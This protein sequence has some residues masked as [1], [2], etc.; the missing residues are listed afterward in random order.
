MFPLGTGTNASRGQRVVEPSYSLPSSSHGQ[1]H[2]SDDVRRQG[3]MLVYEGAHAHSAAW[4]PESPH[5]GHQQQFTGMQDGYFHQHH[6]AHY[7]S[8]ALPL[9]PDAYLTSQ[10]PFPAPAYNITSTMP[11][12]TSEAPG[13]VHSAPPTWPTFSP[14]AG[15]PAHMS[16]PSTTTAASPLGF[17]PWDAFNFSHV[18]HPHTSDYSTLEGAVLAPTVPRTAAPTSGASDPV[19][20]NMD[21]TPPNPSSLWPN[22][23]HGLSPRISQQLSDERSQSES[24]LPRTHHTARIPPESSGRSS[25]I[26]GQPPSSLDVGHSAR[27]SSRL[28]AS[29]PPIAGPSRLPRSSLPPVH[30]PYHDEES[31]ADAEG[32]TEEEEEFESPVQ[33]A[34]KK[35][36]RGAGPK[37][38][39][40]VKL[41]AC[42]TC[43]KKFPRPSG[44]AIHSN[45]HTGEKRTSKVSWCCLPLY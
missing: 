43:G 7:A 16:S 25:F 9:T 15:A 40:K 6:P 17:Y 29:E 33:E 10:D 31:D 32:E 5:A 34:S 45:T 3:R 21:P 30:S 26:F 1:Q 13:N 4:S 27:R 11:N 36:K 22:S 44:L 42:D 18:A 19:A 12:P 41:H 38:P 20:F 24:A 39:K 28:A 2:P 14:I 23:L 8:A 37:R 35:R